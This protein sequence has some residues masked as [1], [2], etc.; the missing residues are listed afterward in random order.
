MDCSV[1]IQT[2]QDFSAVASNCTDEIVDQDIHRDIPIPRMFLNISIFSIAKQTKRKENKIWGGNETMFDQ[3][4]QMM[5]AKI[6]ILLIDWTGF[7]ST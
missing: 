4:S 7:V 3:D 5:K 6:K 2:R 1:Y